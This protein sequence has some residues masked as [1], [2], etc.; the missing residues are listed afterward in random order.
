MDD[1]E[2]FLA[3]TWTPPPISDE[4]IDVVGGLRALRDRPYR[5]QPEP[6]LPPVHPV[7]GW[8]FEGLIR[9]YRESEPT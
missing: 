1:L 9:T 2:A 8:P 4:P 7:T 3:T 5:M 6:P